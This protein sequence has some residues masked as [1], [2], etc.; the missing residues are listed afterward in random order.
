MTVRRKP[1]PTPFSTNDVCSRTSIIGVETTT[2]ARVLLSFGSVMLSFGSVGCAGGDGDAMGDPTGGAS[3]AGAESNSV[4]GGVGSVGGGASGAGVTGAPAAASGG[5]VPSAPSEQLPPGTPANPGP[6]V[7]PDTVPSEDGA[8][9]IDCSSLQRPPTPLR[10]L[11]RFEYDNTVRDL[12]GITSS[13]A[14][15]FP[16]DEISDGFSNNALV[17]T[18]SSLHAERYLDAAEAIAAE[19]VGN[20][21]NLL[22]CAAAADD[23]CALEFAQSFGRRAYRRALEPE[24]IDT[25]MEAYAVGD[26]FEKG[27]EVMIRTMLQSPQFLFRVEYTGSDVPNQGM[28]RLNGYE[29]ATRLSY[30]LWASGPDDALLD[31]AASGGLESPEQV[32]AVTRQMLDDER[33]R[34][35]ITE[36]YRQWLGVTRLD[37]TTK[38]VERFPLWSDEM[39]SAMQAETQA[40]IEQLIWGQQATLTELLS[41]PLGLASGPLAELYG[42]AASNSVVSLPPEQ[43]R[44][45]ILTLPGFLSVTSHPDQTSPVLRGKFVRAKLLCD[46]PPPPPD[47]VDATPP[48][49]NASTAR[50]RFSSHSESA[51]CAGCHALMDPIGFAFESF[52]SVGNYRTMEGGQE[53]DLSGEFVATDDL[54][55]TFTGVPEMAQ[56]LAGSQQVKDCVAT[57]WYKFAMGRG[58][59]DGDACSLSPLRASFTQSGASLMELIIAT[60]QTEAFLYRRAVTQ[61]VT[62]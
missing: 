54:D 18:V 22:P 21:T 19:A 14:D 46:M 37:I 49:P 57:Q 39:R 4:S 38:D 35:A 43:Q 52:D 53:I 1:R 10:R 31:L 8:A 7:A 62:Q 58:E 55:G 59:E 60:T 12:F 51:A 3:I 27:I 47:N 56:R 20:L 61:E 6:S 15:A 24:D 29:T 33:A 32:A 40:V 44:A 2:V 41:S 30:L 13:P 45:G 16:A 11:T 23:A 25:L 36:F 28:V 17:L 48:D 42:V 5:A 34:S 50:E 9:T 26:T